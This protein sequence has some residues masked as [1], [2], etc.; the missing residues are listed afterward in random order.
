MDI[1]TMSN[2]EIERFMDERRKED[3][4]E[5]MDQCFVDPDFDLMHSEWQMERGADPVIPQI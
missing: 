4:Q 3:H 5:I 2:A 1:R